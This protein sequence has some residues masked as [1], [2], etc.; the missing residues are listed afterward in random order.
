MTFGNQKCPQYASTAHI[1][2]SINDAQ[3]QAWVVAQ[4]QR[5]LQ[6]LSVSII[7]GNAHAGRLAGATHGSLTQTIWIFLRKETG[8]LVCTITWCKRRF[9]ECCAN[10][11]F[12]FHDWK[13]QFVYQNRDNWSSLSILTSWDCLTRRRNRKILAAGGCLTCS[14]SLT[15]ECSRVPPSYECGHH[16]R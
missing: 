16:S 6:G 8:T 7:W 10:P 1:H 4:I 14:E 15:H 13:S 2:W 11:F 5:T 12:F 9:V 3:F